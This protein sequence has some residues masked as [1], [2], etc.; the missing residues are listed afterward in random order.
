MKHIL[1]GF[2]PLSSAQESV[3]LVS[4]HRI[5]T[6]AGGAKLHLPN[7]TLSMQRQVWLHARASAPTADHSSQVDSGNAIHTDHARAHD[8]ENKSAASTSV[9]RLNV[10]EPL[11]SPANVAVVHAITS[12]SFA[13]A[14]HLSE[15]RVQLLQLSR[16]TVLLALL[17]AIDSGSEV[18]LSGSKAGVERAQ[19]NNSKRRNVTYGPVVK[20][21]INAAKDSL[22]S[23]RR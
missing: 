7:T 17:D 9:P 13:A 15:R 8:G 23:V 4:F 2:V 5:C 21:I 12:L 19:G 20:R 16:A 6:C 14:S 11:W 10:D 3:S 1:F 18:G 22:E